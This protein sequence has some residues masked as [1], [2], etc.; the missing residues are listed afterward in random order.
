MKAISTEAPAA[1]IDRPRM[2]DDEL[3]DRA[4]GGQGEAFEE[5]VIRYQNRVYNLLLRMTGSGEEAEDLAQETFLKAFRALGSFR[6]GSK[7]YTWLFRI[8]V[9]AAYSRGRKHVLRQQLEGL[10]LD[11]PTNPDWRSTPTFRIE[12]LAAAT[13][14]PGERLEQRLLCERVHEG[15]AQLDS[16]LRTVV[17]LRDIEGLDYETI[18]EA[19]SISYAAVRSRL[20]RGRCELARV[21]R[22]LRPDGVSLTEAG[23]PA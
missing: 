22:D 20:Y 7:F 6:K 23:H 2:P 19:L 8:A 3:V 15:L 17:L 14:E 1:I 4:V 12:Q 5:L 18:S 13:P 16:N 21:L 9:N 11:A 10:S